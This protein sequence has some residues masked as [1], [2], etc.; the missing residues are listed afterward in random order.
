[1]KV[2]VTKGCV[3]Y[4]KTTFLPGEEISL[5]KADAERLVRLG[6]AEIVSE[7]PGPKPKIVMPT[8]QIANKPMEP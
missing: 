8:D 6:V 7:K 2:R 5:K 1:M 4:D 3:I